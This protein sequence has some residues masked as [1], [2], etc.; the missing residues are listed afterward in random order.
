MTRS[1]LGLITLGLLLALGAAPFA[2][3]ARQVETNTMLEL[4]FHTQE[5]YSNPF[6]DVVLDVVFTAPDGTQKRVPAFWAGGGTWKVRYASPVTGIHQY[7]TECNQPQDAG[8][9]E[10]GGEA[11]ITRY[12]GDNPLL[13]HGPIEV[14]GDNR[15]FAHTDGTPF[16][17][18]GDTWW[19]CLCK[20]LTWEGFQEL[21][22]DR[23]AKGFTVAQIV[24]GTYP[25]EDPFE[26]SW[27]NEAG[28]P[29]LDRAF[30]QLNPAYFDYAD[31]RI[32]HLVEAGIVPAIVGGW[33]RPD[34]DAMSFVGVEGLKRHWRYL[35]ARYGAYPVVWIV[36][37]EAPDEVRYGQGP[38]GEG[39]TYLRETDPYHRLTPSHVGSGH[40]EKL[41]VDFDMVGGS[42]DASVAVQRVVLGAFN[43][44]YAGQPPVPVLCGETA[45]EGHMQQ[46]WQDVQR[47]MFWMFILS[48]AAGHTYGAAGIWHAGVEGESGQATAAFGGHKVY[49]WTTWRQGMEYPGSAQLGLC[50]ELLEEYPWYRFEPH[51]EWAEADCYAAGIPGE[52]R[53]IYQ[54]K[55]GIYNWQGA[56]VRHVEADV[57]YNTF[58]FDPATG[59]RFDTGAAKLVSSA[60]ST[61]TGPV[62]PLLLA[63]P[64]DE[65]DPSATWR[66][67]GTPTE[68]TAGHLVAGKNALSIAQQVEGADL[69]VSAGAKSDAEAGLILRFH[70]PDNYLVA[71]YSPHFKCIFLHDRQDGAWGAMLGKVDVPEIGPD[72]HLAAAACGEYAALVVTDGD[73][74]W[75]TPP[76]KINNTTAGKAG[77]WLYQIGEQQQFDNFEVSAAPDAGAGEEPFGDYLAPD[78]PSP[79]DWVLVLERNKD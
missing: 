2:G 62:Q 60:L 14:A 41:V 22:A 25:D 32:G 4:T 59:R 65:Q 17:W 12:A 47:Q 56:I 36:A 46:A 77:L 8:L 33:A 53:F 21:T 52:V 67:Y 51:P 23:K 7:R 68:R 28:K 64:F 72:I 29:Y 18:L 26:A 3:A 76:V 45:Y 31:R 69:I 58:Y 44:A 63:D 74:T 11:D 1:A 75:R 40:Q 15:H 71:L 34:C 6:T 70:D 5:Q 35:I 19:K 10:V 30:T 50:K 13:R 48:G 38:W 73:Q 27:D 16:F 37:G 43:A 57:T 55:R 78:L 79:Q 24:C 39:A 42:H 9:H 49:D 61:F 66:D 54:P 20:R